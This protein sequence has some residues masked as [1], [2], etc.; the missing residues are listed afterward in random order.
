MFENHILW[1]VIGHTFTFL[2]NQLKPST[3]EGDGFILSLYARKT[4]EFWKCQDQGQSSLWENS[5]VVPFPTSV[6][7]SYEA[8]LEDGDSLDF[9]PRLAWKNAVNKYPA[10]PVCFGQQ[11]SRPLEQGLSTFLMLQPFNTVLQVR[12]MPN[13]NII[14]IAT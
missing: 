12:V 4:H 3:L 1:E 6:Q 8:Q 9:E 11:V 10:A 7:S 13:H 5:A 2:Q 14:F